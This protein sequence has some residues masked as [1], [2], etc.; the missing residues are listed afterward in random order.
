MSTDKD[1]GGPRVWEFTKVEGVIGF[2]YK[3]RREFMFYE[4]WLNMYL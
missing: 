3:G 1:S 4:C 2:N